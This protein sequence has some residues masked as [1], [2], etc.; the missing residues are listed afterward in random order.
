MRKTAFTLAL[1]A[2]LA[3]GPAFAFQCPAMMAA[4][5]N[6]LP[7]AELSEADRE[8]VMALRQQGEEAHNAG[9]HAASETAL[10]EAQEIL[11]IN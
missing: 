6:A 7:T 9:D 3:A 10:G 1:V 5:D 8:R 11:G 4:I 2:G